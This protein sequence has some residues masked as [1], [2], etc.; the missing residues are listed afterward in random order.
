VTTIWPSHPASIAQLLKEADGYLHH[1]D[2]DDDISKAIDSLTTAKKLDEKNPQ[3]W[4]KLGWAYWLAFEGRNNDADRVEAFICSSNSLALNPDNDQAHLVQGLVAKN[5]S[6]W[7]SATNHLLRAKQ[8]TKDANG[9]ILISLASACLAAGDDISARG[10]A[11][12]AEHA[13][14]SQWEVFDRLGTF[15]Q[16][17]TNDLSGLQHLQRA[18]QL[19]PQE[20]LPH[21]HLGQAYIFTRQWANAVSEFRSALQLRDTAMAH[22][23]LGS[24]YLAEGNFTEAAR[25]FKK[26]MEIDPNNYRY[27]FGLALSLR[28]QGARE[29]SVAIFKQAMEKVN[30]SLVVSGDQQE[31]HA[32]QGACLAGIGRAEEAVTELDEVRQ[33]GGNN[34][35]IKSI[36]RLG[37]RMLL[38]D[39]KSAEE[40]GRFQESLDELNEQK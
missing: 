3:V 19:A 20:P 39:A 5:Q 30:D 2:C 40:K 18:V 1:Y 6:D 17:A 14:D 12:A 16:G 24:A 37:Y 27:F 32:H 28:E 34:V 29:E 26:A 13:A 7:F 33:Q 15:L 36:L 10:F 35:H 11:Q 23:G 9:L 31:A 21:V 38:Q 4:A 22:G 8:L 25:H